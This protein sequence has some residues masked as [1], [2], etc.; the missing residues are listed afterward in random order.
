MT[1]IGPENLGCF[2]LDIFIM[3]IHGNELG[4]GAYEGAPKGDLYC[5]CKR[6]GSVRN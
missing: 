3:E 5:M 2:T 1:N 4:G 6:G